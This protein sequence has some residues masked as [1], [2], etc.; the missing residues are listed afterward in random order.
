MGNYTQLSD[1][2]Q[3]EKEMRMETWLEMIRNDWVHKSK[4]SLV[5]R[6]RLP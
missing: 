1:S 6:G 2:V 5:W 4:R 3:Y